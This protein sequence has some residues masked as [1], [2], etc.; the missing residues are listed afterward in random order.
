MLNIDS[1]VNHAI[2]TIV[3]IIFVNFVNKS[4]QILATLK[5]MING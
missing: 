5:M 4:I 3:I 1:Y 2:K